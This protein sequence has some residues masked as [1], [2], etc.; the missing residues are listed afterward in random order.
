[1][2]YVVG[3]GYGVRSINS[4]RVPGG[5]EPDIPRSLARIFRYRVLDI[6]VR[7]ASASGPK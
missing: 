7:Q 4:G 3:V 1:M 5:D 2:I 6:P